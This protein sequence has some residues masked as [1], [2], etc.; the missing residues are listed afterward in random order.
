MN[1]Q[2]KVACF[3]VFFFFRPNWFYPIKLCIPTIQ[4]FLLEGLSSLRNSTNSNLKRRKY[5]LQITRT[6]RNNTERS[7]VKDMFYS[8]YKENVHMK[9]LCF[10]KDGSVNMTQ[11][12]LLLSINNLLYIKYKVVDNRIVD[13]I[14]SFMIEDTLK[15]KDSK[16]EF[17]CFRQ[18]K[19]F[20][21]FFF[22]SM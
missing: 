15:K 19:F 11:F 2:I 7:L 5:V 14:I 17:S 9:K 13:I 12:L 3:L 10:C 1:T 16:M 18:I 21:H 20:S 8:S 22:S 6:F 4:V